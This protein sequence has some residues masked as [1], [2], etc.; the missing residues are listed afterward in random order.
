MIRQ[1]ANETNSSQNLEQYKSKT[2]QQA[3]QNIV[4]DILSACIAWR[5]RK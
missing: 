1:F 3:E 4:P 2:F 5:L